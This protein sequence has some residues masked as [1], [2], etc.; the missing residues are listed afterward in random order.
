V[1]E[2]LTRVYELIISFIASSGAR[3]LDGGLGASILRLLSIVPDDLIIGLCSVSGKA[4]PALGRILRGLQGEQILL[5]QVDK[6]QVI[7]TGKGGG[8]ATG[9]KSGKL[10]SAIG[11]PRS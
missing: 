3:A 11:L 2:G 8:G 5:G 1:I 9:A 7:G 6:G 4:G 10:T